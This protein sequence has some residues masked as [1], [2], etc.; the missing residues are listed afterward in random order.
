MRDKEYIYNRFLRQLD[1]VSPEKLCFP[2]TVIGAGAIGSAAV[3]SLAKMGCSSI[4]VWDDD[5]LEEMNVPNQL[6]KPALVGQLK[7]DALTELVFELTGVKVEGIPR[8][9]GGQSLKGVVIMSVDTMTSRQVAWKRVRLNPWIPLLI[10]ARMGAEFAR[11]YAIHPMD[12]VQI[13]FYE[14]NLYGNDEAERL[15]CSARSIIYCPAV[16]GGLIALLVK[17]FAMNRPVPQEVL[18]DLPHFILTCHRGGDFHG[19]SFLQPDESVY[20]V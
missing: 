19:P 6:C 17:Q 12:I 7:V 5:R 4:S 9:Y 2:I 18:F 11:M 10:D 14:Q 20:A 13:E 8:R 1:I 3:V 16:I 15:P